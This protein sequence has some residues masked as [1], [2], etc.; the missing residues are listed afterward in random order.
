MLYELN[1]ASGTDSKRPVGV[2]H[3]RP[4]VFYRDSQGHNLLQTVFLANWNSTQSSHYF[5]FVA[6]V[7]SSEFMAVRLNHS[8][9]IREKLGWH[10]KVKWTQI[11]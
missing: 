8:L 6:F 2:V 1:G 9:F 11:N 5:L 7:Y 4:I 10:S 3:E